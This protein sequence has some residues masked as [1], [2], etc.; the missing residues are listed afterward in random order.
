MKDDRL[1]NQV[2]TSRS[3][4]L[5]LV[6][7]VFNERDHLAALL[8]GLDEQTLVPDQIVIVD[9]YSTDG[10]WELLNDWSRSRRSRALLGQT[11]KSIEPEILI[12]Q[13]AGGISV[14]RN[15][16]I[17]LATGELIAT[18]DAGCV[19]EPEWLAH[20]MATWSQS[21]A[22]LVA[23]H[24]VGLPSNAFEAAQVPF[25]LVMDSKVRA[26]N[27]LPATRS[28]LL[29]KT[30]W[31]E[32]GGFD[33]KLLVSE[34]Y[35]FSIAARRAGYKIVFCAQARVGWLP[36]PNLLAFAKMVAGQATY[37]L[38][39]G[40]KRVQVDWLIW[41]WS[42]A[43]LGLMIFWLVQPNWIWPLLLFLAVLFV[44]LAL[45]RRGRGLRLASLLWL[46]ILHLVSDWAVIFGTL[47]AQLV[48]FDR[49]QSRSD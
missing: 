41:R 3:A 42:V 8:K 26:G 22:D 44:G 37:D 47:R 28:M 19:P 11:S 15:R 20:L 2:L 4:K 5:S 33:E 9:A 13:K 21:E 6:V 35:A 38:L 23:G 31:T 17:E 29:K 34:D 30:V 12:E 45:W 27:Y 32:L 16:G 24:A 43:A 49:R 10:T 40:I 46:P 7:T 39:G 48:G 36:R 18:T 14:G 25:V 1:T